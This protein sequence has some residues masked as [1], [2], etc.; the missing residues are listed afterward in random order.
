MLQSAYPWS[1]RAITHCEP[2]QAAVACVRRQTLPQAPQ[3]AASF[4]KV[5]SQPLVALLSQL[6]KPAL[7]VIVQPPT[8]QP[9]TPFAV[10]HAR[11]HE[12]QWVGSMAMLVS[13][14]SFGSALQSP[15]P[16][17]QLAIWQAPSTHCGDTF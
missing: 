12:P 1:H 8:A 2:P 13:Q 11:A 10:E 14:P 16:A 6:P 15:N 9:A 3:L 7:Q 4:E 5:I 17:L